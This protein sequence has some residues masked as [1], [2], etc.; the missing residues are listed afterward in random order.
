[1]SRQFNL[2]RYFSIVSLVLI[3]LVAIALS[4]AYHANAENELVRLGENK[5]QAQSLLLLNA[6]DGE[7]K[8]H[9]SG[10]IASTI[11]P[12][13]DDPNVAA[14]RAYLSRL[15]AG[16][17]VVKI[18]LYNAQGLTVFSS[19]TK[20]IGEQK[21]KNPGFQ[22]ALRGG[23]ETELTHRGKFSAFDGDLE[24]LDVLGSYLPLHDD[25]NRVVGVIEVYDDVTGVVQTIY[26]TSYLVFGLTSALMLLLYGALMVVVIKADR[27]LRKYAAELQV[28]SREREQALALAQRDRELA[29]SARKEAILNHKEAE[30]ARA[31]AD[32]ANRAKSDFLANM[33]HEIRTPMN[34][35]IGFTD[36]VLHEDLPAK[37]RE[38]VS[39][40]K[41]SAI[42]LLSIINDILDLSK[43]E[44]GKL[45]LQTEQFSPRHLVTQLVQMFA[46]RAVEKGLYLH[47]EF[48]EDVPDFLAGDELRL[49]QVLLNLLDNALKFT[50]RGTIT[51]AIRRMQAD[52]GI[53][54]EFKVR[55]TGIGIDAKN[56]ER[57]FEPF[58]QAGAQD[59]S[60][61]A[62]GT[63]LG[64]AIC[65]RLV[66][67]M[68]GTLEVNS[69]PGKGSEFVFTVEFAKIQVADHIV[70]TAPAPIATRLDRQA[71]QSKTVLLVEDHIINQKLAQAM[72]NRIGCNLV[73]A[74]NGKEGV[75]MA[76]R[77]GIDLILMDMQMPVMDGM[78]A[79]QQIRA[80]ELATGRAPLP[81]VALTAN[82][83]EADKEACI[84]IGMNGFLSKPYQFADLDEMVR[85][86]LRDQ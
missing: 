73:L 15:T 81:I 50:D 3:A 69:A 45:E 16:S 40:I 46:P 9:W 67:L 48:A 62:T 12:A 25:V 71:M 66:Q 42:S 26:R 58:E 76:R 53:R 17:S 32:R 43:V 72:F 10:L 63:G 4:L 55:D 65:M 11:A 70:D 74:V 60:Q 64:L 85:R 27:I 61:R 2:S 49:R 78:Q 54:L 77:P 41:G 7:S 59:G 51:V 68:N 30:A 56:I 29:D 52:V 14:L 23:R 19:E 47:A 75:E 13:K 35:I 36:L 34:G 24:N 21:F 86:Y 18:K 79:T 5:N 80:E 84:A 37:Q 82:A 1:M 6:M 38:Y 20:Q 31:D 22:A 44:A 33:S 39:L 83:M 28:E 57:I 8:A